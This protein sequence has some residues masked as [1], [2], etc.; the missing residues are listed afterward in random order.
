MVL[1]EHAKHGRHHFYSPAEVEQAKLA[2]WSVVVESAPEV[3]DVEPPKP[4]AKVL[5]LKAKK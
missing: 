4:P 3:T 2:G 1:M 5:S